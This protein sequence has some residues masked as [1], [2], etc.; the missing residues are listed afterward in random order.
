MIFEK[1]VKEQIVATTAR[2]QMRIGGAPVM[3]VV[4]ITYPLCNDA[5][6][7]RCEPLRFGK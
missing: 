5:D 1:T 2:L 3:R 6:K 4:A 7:N